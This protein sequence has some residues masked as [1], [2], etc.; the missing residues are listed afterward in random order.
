MQR[1]EISQRRLDEEGI[2]SLRAGVVQFDLLSRRW[3]DE[4]R[5]NENTQRTID[6][7]RH[8][9]LRGLGGDSPHTAASARVGA[10]PGAGEA[11]ASGAGQASTRGSQSR[12]RSSSSAT[13]VRARRPQKRS[14][15]RKSEPASSSG[16]QRPQG[17]EAK[18]M[19]KPGEVLAAP[20][21]AKAASAKL[22]PM[23]TPARGGPP[24]LKEGA[25]VRV[26]DGWVTGRR[27]P[28]SKWELESWCADVVANMYSCR[29]DGDSARG[30]VE[31]AVSASALKDHI[32][33][34]I[35]SL[36]SR[37]QR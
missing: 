20:R 36:Q 19:P 12:S 11:A 29:A 18:P 34:P 35:H 16:I 4:L 8:Q 28:E 5:R 6:D 26:K 13:Q 25:W 7:A 14:P 33:C 1:I 21:P 32:V 30:Y 31:A 24:Y 37:L 17:C 22:E 2:V 27:Q 15:P 3:N 10:A 9:L 23:R